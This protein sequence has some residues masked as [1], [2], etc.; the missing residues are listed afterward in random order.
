M[1]Y[2]ATITRVIDGDTLEATIYDSPFFGVMQS[3]NE[4]LRLARI[5][6]P[7]VR[8]VEKKYGLES[9]EA[10][11]ELVTVINKCGHIVEVEA[12]E[13][14]SFG[15]YIAEVWFKLKVNNH[16]TNLSTWMVDCGLAEY[17]EY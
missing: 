3:T 1:R 14:D 11:K 13:T 9:E 6:A 15:R 8:G 12:E 16:F 5:D 7:E 17:K 4:T 10:L 2:K